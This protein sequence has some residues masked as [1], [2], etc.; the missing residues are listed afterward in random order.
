MMK[1]L[2]LIFSLFPLL[3]VAEPS[4][5]I[6]W[7]PELLNFVKAGNAENGKKLATACAGCHGEDG[8]S[9]TPGY[10]SLA[11]QMPTYL[12]KQLR[13]YAD[14]SRSDA[15]MSAIAQGLSEQD[16]ADLAAWYASLDKQVKGKTANIGD[17]AERLV[18]TGD[19][20]RTLAPCFVC[21]GANGEGEK[22]DIPA[23]AGQRQDYLIKSMQD[24]KAG[25][26]KNDIYQRMRLIAEQLTDKEIIAIAEY[27]KSLR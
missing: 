8:I 1:K 19:G 22:M 11:G 17:T 5:H 4:T 14:G 21:H 23:L 3:V 13:D 18:F 2:V 9:K 26:R 6:A 15:M 27:Y 16:S 24:F 7:T 12:Y 10:P 20:K 25:T